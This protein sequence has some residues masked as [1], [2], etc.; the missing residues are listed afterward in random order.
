MADYEN[1]LIKKHEKTLEKKEKAL[2]NKKTLVKEKDKE[3]KEM[4]KKYKTLMVKAGKSP[5]KEKL[6]EAVETKSAEVK[7][8]AEKTAEEKA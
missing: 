1:D 2:T 7:S 5:S 6:K 8:P 4:M 3:I